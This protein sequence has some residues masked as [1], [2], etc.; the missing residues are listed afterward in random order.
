M[1]KARRGRIF[2]VQYNKSTFHDN[3]TGTGRRME[4]PRSQRETPPR[5]RDRARKAPASISHPEHAEL[6]AL[7]RRAARDAE[8]EAEHGARVGRVDD[9]VVPDAR[10]G[11]VAR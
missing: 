6:F 8:R 1:P 2:I 3:S 7:V 11:E 10:R 5:P 9:A 4:F